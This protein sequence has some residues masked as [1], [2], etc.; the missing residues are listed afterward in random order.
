MR[1]PK[2][3]NAFVKQNDDFVDLGVLNMTPVKTS[4]EDEPENIQL[5]ILE[6]K[7]WSARNKVIVRNP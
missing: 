5:E 3:R 4:E 1:K 7:N 6:P 2:P